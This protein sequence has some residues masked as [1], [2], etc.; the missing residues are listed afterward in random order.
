MPDAESCCPAVWICPC[1]CCCLSSPTWIVRS[2]FVSML[3]I[4]QITG[5]T[6]F[7]NWLGPSYLGVSCAAALYKRC[8]WDHTTSFTA[9]VHCLLVRLYSLAWSWD[10]FSIFS[11]SPSLLAVSSG[12]S[13][14]RPVPRAT[15]L[16]RLL[17]SRGYLPWVRNAGV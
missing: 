9:G 8:S 14:A 17:W 5:E 15:L 1:V 6:K 4:L 11:I 3:R 16:Y 2:F 12:V 10:A 13:V 7:T